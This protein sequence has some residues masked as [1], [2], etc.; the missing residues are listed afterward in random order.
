MQTPAR[1]AHPSHLQQL[2]LQL[3]AGLHHV[4]V[5]LR[6]HHRLQ[7]LA[8]KLEAHALQLARVVLL[9]QRQR[10]GYRL[11]LRRAGKKKAG[12]RA[13][14][15]VGGQGCRGRGRRAGE[16]CPAWQRGA[17]APGRALRPAAQPQHGSGSLLQ[18][19]LPWA[20]AQLTSTVS[21]SRCSQMQRRRMS[22]KRSA[23]ASR[24][25]AIVTSSFAPCSSAC[26]AS[27]G[28]GAALPNQC[29]WPCRA[30]WVDA[31][32]QA[33][34]SA[35]D[36]QAS[37]AAPGLPNPRQ[38]AEAAQHGPLQPVQTEDSSRQRQ[39]T[40]ADLGLGRRSVPSAAWDSPARP[41]RRGKKGPLKD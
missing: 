1:P 3:R 16:V 36:M 15:E 4:V 26:K 41:I 34:D 10:R 37:T 22:W 40:A 20:A 19:C 7:V 33:G 38:L 39:E 21:H 11:H 6:G 31:A 24:C 12:K 29:S 28:R 17:R 23:A 25:C 8:D 13:A 27:V 32:A 30:G 35:R 18:A 5:S 9:R 14:G 2:R